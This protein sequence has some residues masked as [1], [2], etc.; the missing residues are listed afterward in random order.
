MGIHVTTGP[1]Y[2]QQS[3][4]LYAN[5]SLCCRID[6]KQRSCTA[7][8]ILSDGGSTNSSCCHR[9][10]MPADK[11]INQSLFVRTF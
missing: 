11:S 8:T 6:K 5:K 10:C 3:D 9:C 1:E 4:K 2:M 7:I